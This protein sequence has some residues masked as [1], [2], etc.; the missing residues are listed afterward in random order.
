MAIGAQVW[1]T[2]A[3]GGTRRQMI[4]TVL[5]GLILG[6]GSVT[7]GT[8]MVHASERGGLFDFFEDLFRGPPKS[9]AAPAPRQPV[10]YANL[11]DGRRAGLPR[12]IL[13][14]PRPAAD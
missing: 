1:R 11:P 3:S 6:L 5:A 7:V 9:E 8:G 14:T 13:H 4:G 12:P 2:L 10:R